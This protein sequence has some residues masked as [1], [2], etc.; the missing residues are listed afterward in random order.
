M[1]SILYMTSFIPLL[2]DPNNRDSMQ[3]SLLENTEQ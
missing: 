3:K 1:V 2:L